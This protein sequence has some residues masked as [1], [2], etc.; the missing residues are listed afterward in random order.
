MSPTTA[1][2]LL[3]TTGDPRYSCIFCSSGDCVRDEDGLKLALRLT[4]AAPG[5]CGVGSSSAALGSGSVAF[6]PFF[7]RGGAAGGGLLD[8]VMSAGSPFCTIFVGAGSLLWFWFWFW[9][10]FWTW[11]GG[12]SGAVWRLTRTFGTAAVCSL[13]GGP[14]GGG[15]GLKTGL[16]RTRPGLV[17]SP[18]S[19]LDGGRGAG[20][21]TGLAGRAGRSG[22]ASFSP[23]CFD[24]VVAGSCDFET[25]LDGGIGRS[26]VMGGASSAGL[27]CLVAMEIEDL[28]TDLD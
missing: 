19:C 8:L 17:A 4:L 5:P 21:K 26:V 9:I 28:E 10:G 11:I 7:F 1:F 20:L 27:S 16:T 2:V 25:D 12:S 24:A 3:I 13:G 18:P 14:A 22:G 15:G 23:F 6:P